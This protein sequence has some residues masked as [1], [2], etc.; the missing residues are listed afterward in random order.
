MLQDFDIMLSRSPVARSAGGESG[1]RTEFFLKERILRDR[2]VCDLNGAISSAFDGL[3]LKM[4]PFG[5]TIIVFDV[6][7][8][9]AG[10]FDYFGC[11]EK[12][13]LAP[14]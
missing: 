14:A 5:P 11:K 4:I 7:F 2:K 10:K 9:L 3:S 8:S 12:I 1:G 6:H 13:S